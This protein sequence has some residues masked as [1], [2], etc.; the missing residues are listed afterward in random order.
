MAVSKTATTRDNTAWWGRKKDKKIRKE[1]R[2]EEIFVRSCLS[3]TVT[4][5]WQYST[6]LHVIRPGIQLKLNPSKAWRWREIKRHAFIQR[7]NILVNDEFDLICLEILLREY[8]EFL[9]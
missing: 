2:K 5:E 8:L 3:T 9:F 1:E 7:E 6:L 4:Q